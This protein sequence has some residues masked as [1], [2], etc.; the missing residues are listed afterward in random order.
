MKFKSCERS[1][2]VLEILDGVEIQWKPNPTIRNK[3]CECVKPYLE[4]IDKYAP[5]SLMKAYETILRRL[6]ILHDKA[7]IDGFIEV[8]TKIVNAVKDKI[9]EELNIEFP[10]LTDQFE[11]PMTIEEF[12]RF[13]QLSLALKLASFIIHYAKPDD[14]GI[15]PNYLLDRLV[16]Y[17]VSPET[18]KKIM[19][20]I[21]HTTSNSYYSREAM[22]KYLIETVGITPDQHIQ[23]TINYFFRAML[24][25]YDASKQPNIMSYL[26]GYVNQ[27]LYYLFTDTYE[28]FAQYINIAKV[29]FSKNYNLI[30][31]QAVFYLFENIAKLMRMLYPSNKDFVEYDIVSKSFNIIPYEINQRGFVV[32]PISKYVTYPLIK[33]AFDAEYNYIS[34]FRDIRYIEVYMSFVTE[35]FLKL[36]YLA[37]LMRSI[38]VSKNTKKKIKVNRIKLNN[39]A[40]KIESKYPILA[41]KKFMTNVVQE[42]KQYIYYDPVIH[43]VFHLDIETFIDEIYEFYKLF[44]LEPQNLKETLRPISVSYKKDEIIDMHKK[45]AISQVF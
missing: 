2:V 10:D 32:N 42:S 19:K 17:Y 4:L 37:K 43:D 18:S 25:L 27:S 29:R 15:N 13:Y 9:K 22:W 38:V 31:Q 26:A 28:R 24:T 5:A 8:I 16:K 34:E 44:F 45:H 21:S 1:N 7:Q 3:F 41:K 23:N 20:F 39:F 6:F 14:L 35:R 12:D 36:P 11:D 33:I 40:K 30:K